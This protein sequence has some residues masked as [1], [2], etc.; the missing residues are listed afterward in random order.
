MASTSFNG[1]LING[2]RRNPYQSAGI[3]VQQFDPSSFVI[4]NAVRPVED[5]GMSTPDVGHT[6]R[7]GVQNMGK[8]THIL[9]IDLH[10]QRYGRNTLAA[11]S[12]IQVSLGH[13]DDHAILERTALFRQVEHLCG[14]L[15]FRQLYIYAYMGP[16]GV[17]GRHIALF[18]DDLGAAVPGGHTVLPFVTARVAMR[19]ALR[20]IENALSPG[21]FLVSPPRDLYRAWHHFVT[22]VR[23]PSLQRAESELTR[24]DQAVEHLADCLVGRGASMGALIPVNMRNFSFA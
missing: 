20:L 19:T 1:V 22:T 3:Q 11:G 23:R 7:L 10:A 24:A 2:V 4:S 18:L 16:E 17:G 6:S 12:R 21:Q 13:Q 15:D 14:C 9:T 5:E 8:I